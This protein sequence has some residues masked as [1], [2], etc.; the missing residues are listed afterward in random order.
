MHTG[1]KKFYCLWKW[2]IW[3][4]L[5][6]W[7]IKGRKEMVVVQPSKIAPSTCSGL[8]YRTSL[9][10]KKSLIYPFGYSQPDLLNEIYYQSYYICL[11]CWGVFPPFGLRIFYRNETKC[12]I[13]QILSSKNVYLKSRAIQVITASEVKRE[14]GLPP[15]N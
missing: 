3:Q 14:N 6:P 9:S 11:I 10:R 12:Q 2:L 7:H 8:T 13:F 15:L 1:C 5:K 4:S